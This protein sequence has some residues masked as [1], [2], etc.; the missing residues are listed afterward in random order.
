MD[1][2]TDQTPHLPLRHSNRVRAPPTHLHVFFFFFAVIS[3]HEPHTYHEACTSP[4][5]QQAMIEEL[6]ALEKTHINGS[7]RSRLIRV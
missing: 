6:Q 7:T 1:H 2:V 4:L 5:L 3:L